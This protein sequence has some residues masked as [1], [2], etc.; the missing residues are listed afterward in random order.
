MEL[1]IKESSNTALTDY[2]IKVEVPFVTGM[3]SDYSDLRITDTDG[4]TFL[5]FY[6]EYYDADK[7]IIWLKIPAIA[8]SVKKSFWIYYCNAAATSYSNPEKT[9]I[10]YDGFESF[11]GWNNLSNGTGVHDQ[12]TF[13]GINTIK[14]DGNCDPSGSYKLLGQTVNSFRL[15]AREQRR[16]EGL[17][18]TLNRYGLENGPGNG[19]NIRRS[20]TSANN[21]AF[22]FERRNGGTGGNYQSTTLA[23]PHSNW[24]RTELT[25]CYKNLADLEDDITT[26]TLNNDD[27]S[28][29]GS[30]Q[31]SNTSHTSFDRVTIRGGRPYFFDF[32]AV[33][34]FICEEPEY[35]LNKPEH[36]IPIIV[37]QDITVSLDENGNYTLDPVDLISSYE[38]CNDL[39]FTVNQSIFDCSDIGNNSIKIIAT[40][41]CGNEDGCK[42]RLTIVD[43]TPPIISCPG[44]IT[45]DAN[46]AGCSAI[47]SWTPAT[48]TDNCNGVDITSTHEPN[49]R[50]PLG[51]TTVT[52]YAE[53][54]TGNISSCSFDIEVISNATIPSISIEEYSG[55]L[56]DD[57]VIC[58]GEKVCLTAETGFANYLWN[59]SDVGNTLCV[60]TGGIYSVVVT[61]DIGCTNSSAEVTIVSNNNPIAGTCNLLH[62]YC[63]NNEGEIQIEVSD[64]TAPYSVDWTPAIGGVSNGVI[65]ASGGILNIE[66]IP[67]GTT[68]NFS[69]VDQN[70]CIPQ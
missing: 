27:Y 43:D 3:K 20:A 11:S 63:Q 48:A 8:A 42:A 51:I 32:I 29:V 28:N 41:G 30:H 61:N 40:D 55:L 54:G 25:R 64:G 36:D 7:A 60:S 24:Y 6:L 19:Y 68:I 31:G 62:D 53:D 17:D 9:F 16:N 4:T 34:K 67:G 15:I 13:P 66:N 10:F 14:K 57:G 23:Q 52:Y 56:E 69:V 2:Q 46:Q 35:D 37:C 49:S 70:G 12:T 44:D 39:D 45:I 18:C 58:E 47:V 26:A 38:D 21:G 33:G 5:N 65:N 50:F 1:Q 22:G 59:T